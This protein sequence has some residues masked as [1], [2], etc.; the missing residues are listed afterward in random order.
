[1]KDLDPLV[2]LSVFEEMLGP[3]LWL[4]LAVVIL[5]IIAFASLL[6]R[7]RHLVSRRLVRSEVLG[8]AGGALALVLM[9]KVSSSGFTGAGSPADWLLIALVFGAGLVGST[10][11][12]YTMACWW[13]A[14]RKPTLNMNTK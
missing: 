10:I 8:V 14:L 7:E 4:L 13:T 5:G 6:L 9:A 12:F 1:M 2:L 3:L 11:L